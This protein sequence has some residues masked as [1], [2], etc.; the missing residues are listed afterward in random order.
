V[1][2]VGND[3]DVRIAPICHFESDS[4]L[5]VHPTLA[6]AGRVELE[7]RPVD[8]GGG[9]AGCARL[10]IANWNVRASLP[11]PFIIRRGEM[12]EFG[13]AALLHLERLIDDCRMVLRVRSSCMLW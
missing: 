9:S 7:E 3:E 10:P 2:L 5:G 8:D 11:T 4:K 12:Q 13:S 1:P 6:V